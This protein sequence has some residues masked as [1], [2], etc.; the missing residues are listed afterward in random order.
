M[1][2]QVVCVP[3]SVAP[4]AQRYRPLIE[5]AGEGADLHLKD[6]EVY[7]ET[8]PPEDYSIEEEVEAID[9]FADS[10]G[11]DRFHL[12][13]YSGGGF[14][15]LA[16]AGTRPQRV[17]SLALFE[18]ARIPGPLSDAERAFF[19]ELEGK[20]R[21][22]EGDQFMTV[23]VREQV[24]PGAQLPPPPSGPP[25]PEM[26]KRPA[27]IAALIRAFEAHPFDRDRLRTAPFPVFYGYGDL[28]HPEQALKAGILAELIPDIHVRRFDG[29]HHFVPPEQIYTAEHAAELLELWRRSERSVRQLS[30]K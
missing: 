18:P 9:R 14:I 25:S 12:V 3:G 23:F 8:A 30:E 6:L 16:Y 29:V 17:I 15:S 11:L 10:R 26:R 22:L 19:A 5:A 20:L 28:S 13:A 2:L 27:G 7:R 24:K 1:K 21:G 4:A